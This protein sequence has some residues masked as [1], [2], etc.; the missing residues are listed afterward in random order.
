M[1]ALG[2]FDY[3]VITIS[4][5]IVFILVVSLFLYSRRK[6]PAAGEQVRTGVRTILANFTFVWVLMA[7]LLFYIATVDMRSYFLFVVG[8]VVVELFLVYYIMKNRSRD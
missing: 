5:S 7:L 6:R 8:N 3:Y 4:F 1:T 2:L